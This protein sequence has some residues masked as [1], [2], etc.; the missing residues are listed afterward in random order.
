MK[1]QLLSITWVTLL[2]L[3]LSARATVIK[4]FSDNT[5]CLQSL[6][7]NNK[8]I[9]NHLVPL[10]TIHSLE[11]FKASYPEFSEIGGGDNMELYEFAFGEKQ[12]EVKFMLDGEITILKALNEDILE[13]KDLVT[14][15]VNLH[16]NFFM[17]FFMDPKYEHVHKALLAKY[18]DFKSLRFAF[19]DD[20]PEV[21]E[22]L[23]E[24]F[25]LANSRLRDFLIQFDV[26]DRIHFKDH[27]SIVSKP[28][29]WFLMGFG[30]TADL[31]NVT[32]RFMRTY[33]QD[34]EDIHIMSFEEIEEEL[35][36][37]IKTIESRRRRLVAVYQEMLPMMFQKIPGSNDYTLSTKAIH[38]LMKTKARSFGKKFN[39]TP[40]D[41]DKVR[42]L[43]KEDYYGKV[44]ARFI[45]AFKIHGQNLGKQVQ[46]DLA[47][48]SPL[49]ATDSEINKAL[50]GGPLVKN[51]LDITATLEM[52]N[53]LVSRNL[54]FAART[55]IN[56]SDIF[57]PS[58]F[59]DKR[60]EHRFDDVD[61]PVISFDFTG[62]NVRNIEQTLFALYNSREQGAR[63]AVQNTRSG[64][65]VATAVLDELRDIAR[66]SIDFAYGIKRDAKGNVIN[67]DEDIP[68]LFTGD[69]GIA[70]PAELTGVHKKKILNYLNTSPYKAAFRVTFSDETVKSEDRSY[71]IGEAES[72]EKDLR[73]M[74]EHFEPVEKIDQAIIAVDI[75]G[76][77]MENANIAVQY[78]GPLTKTEV[79]TALKHVLQQ[80]KYPQEVIDNI[81][82]ERV[83]PSKKKHPRPNTYKKTTQVVV[84]LELTHQSAILFCA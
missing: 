40:E 44:R 55:Y 10:I 30:E 46:F 33:L 26:V 39:L 50:I 66:K 51:M 54:V 32:A 2:L 12:G 5:G 49:E 27:R 48:F 18:S 80:K 59:V 70:F 76:P 37:I 61:H 63:Q 4:S 28:K 42:Y 25:I 79:I 35:D 83:R 62:Q 81:K 41:R 52:Q 64:E 71:V 43:E 67:Q 19:N 34:D 38:I 72:I 23:S 31:A 56:L 74:L 73:L 57:S 9:R 1:R 21:K 82:I 6:T 15:I 7:N 53:A 29:R 16:K 24:V 13:D 75:L 77:N 17:Y 58:I 36:S 8:S 68:L 65:F 11:E 14:K 78:V 3:G 60:I 20:S 45:R 22:S 84:P 69:D 47:T